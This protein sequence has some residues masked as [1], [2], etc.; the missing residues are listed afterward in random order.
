MIHYVVHDLEVR[1]T[2]SFRQTHAL[3]YRPCFGYSRLELLRPIFLRGR[4]NDL[5]AF[6][7]E[8]RGVACSDYPRADDGD[9]LDFRRLRHREIICRGF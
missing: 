2:S 9:G 3:Q 1:L 4:G 7:Q 5:E 8:K 6:G